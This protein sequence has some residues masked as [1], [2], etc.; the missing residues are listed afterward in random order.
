M[1]RRL[2]GVLASAALVLAVGAGCDEDSDSG[3]GSTTTY[4]LSGN[5]IKSGVSGVRGYLKLVAPGAPSTSA[6]KYWTS[7]TVF[8]NGTATYTF[9]GVATGSYDGYAFID[10]NGSSAGGASAFPDAGDWTAGPGE[11]TITGN[12]VQNVQEDDWELYN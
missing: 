9:S 7:S 10:M 6:P 4:T 3:A 5:L 1:T 12:Q 2:L 11:I 8:S